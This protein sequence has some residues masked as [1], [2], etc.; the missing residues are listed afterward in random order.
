MLPLGSF[1]PLNQVL[2]QAPC[3]VL[4]SFGEIHVCGVMADVQYRIEGV[5]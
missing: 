5:V 3:A 4:D 1:P 2:L